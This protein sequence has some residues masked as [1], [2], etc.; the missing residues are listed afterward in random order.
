[1]TTR[2][3]G[4]G[5]RPSLGKLHVSPHGAV[6]SD[7]IKDEKQG[8]LFTA[9]NTLPTAKLHVENRRCHYRPT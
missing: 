7:A 1:M 5:R 9:R 6:S 4:A 3:T 2:T 8:S